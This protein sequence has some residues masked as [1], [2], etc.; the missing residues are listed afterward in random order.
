MESKR[1]KAV[2][3]DDEKE[4]CDLIVELLN[5]DGHEVSQYSSAE[6]FL[7]AVEKRA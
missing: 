4:I 5:R 7:K 3:I 2:I 1:I 6:S